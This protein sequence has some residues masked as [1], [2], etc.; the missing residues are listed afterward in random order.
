MSNKFE[1]FLLVFSHF[2][3]CFDQSSRNNCLKCCNCFLRKVIFDTITPKG[4]SFDGMRSHAS[5]FSL[6]RRP[7]ELKNWSTK[8][9][10]PVDKMLKYLT[11]KESLKNEYH[12]SDILSKTCF[13]Y[14]DQNIY[15][16]FEQG[17]FETI[18]SEKNKRM[19][20]LMCKIE[21]LMIYDLLLQSFHCLL[22]IQ[23]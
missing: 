15:A 17:L 4:I 16:K 11:T 7:T 18:E 6:G 8:L 10:K 2:S 22:Y 21:L 5:K 3:D 20:Q 13:V 1:L 12:L 14:G 23:T 9:I 19:F